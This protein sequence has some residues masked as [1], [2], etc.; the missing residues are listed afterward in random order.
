MS[1]AIFYNPL[2]NQGEDEAQWGKSQKQAG[3]SNIVS[4]R[5]QGADEH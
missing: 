1:A 4:V 5:L 2:H 3:V